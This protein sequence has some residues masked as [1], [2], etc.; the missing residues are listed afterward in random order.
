[1]KALV[2]TSTGVTTV[3]DI[4][5]DLDTLQSLVGGYI[6][7]APTDGSVT[8]YV[9]EEGK[10]TGLPVNP[11]ATRLY[12]K[13]APFMEG[14]DILVGTVVILGPVDD[15]GEETEVPASVLALAEVE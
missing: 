13:L 14:H 3:E 9:N 11:E 10:V 2:I 15:E 8:V 4:T 6:E 1:M 12:Y 5:P 7:A